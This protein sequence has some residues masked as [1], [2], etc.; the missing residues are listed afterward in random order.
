MAVGDILNE[1]VA[2]RPLRAAAWLRP[3]IWTAAAIVTL[4]VAIAPDLIDLPRPQGALVFDR[5]SYTPVNGSARDVTMPH[6][7]YISFREVL[8]SVRYVFKFEPQAGAQDDLHVYV[9]SFNRRI[10]LSVNGSVFFDSETETIWTGAFISSSSLIQI[11]RAILVAGQN[12]LTIDVF[13]VD[14]FAVPVHLSEV[15]V[16]TAAALSWPFKLRVFFQSQLKI[17]AL[18]VHFVF[19]VGLIA[20]YF[21][22][23][24]DPLYSW[25]AV[26][27][28][29]NMLIAIGML[30]GWQPAVRSFVL[31]FTVLAPAMGLLFIGF[32]LALVGLRP[33]KM[34]AY[35]AIAI[36]GALVPFTFVDT[37]FSKIVL[38]A[39]GGGVTIASLCAAAM[40]FAWSAIRRGDT[41]AGLM[42]P[43]AFLL[44]W[45]A[46][47]DTFV[48]ATLPAH[49]FNLLIPYVRPVFFSFLTVVLLRR[50]GVTL[51]QLDR[52]NEN[53]S[54]RLAEREAELAIFHRQEKAKTAHLVREQERHRL[55]HDLH[56]GISGHLASIIALSERTGDKS[57]EQAAR[58]ALNDLRLVIYSLDLDDS[59]LPVALAN[60]RDRL[61]PQLHRLGIELDW[62]IAGLPEVSGVT[63][64]NALAILRILQ[65]AVTNAVKHGPA[66]RIV[67]RASAAAGD[68]VMITVENDGRAFSESGTGQSLGG[69]GLGNMRRRAAGL[70]GDVTIDALP[71]GTRLTL[72]LPRRFPAF[73]DEAAT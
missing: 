31:L 42:L 54:M 38:A 7:I 18:A 22:R 57:T 36:T 5:A 34:L 30:I 26:F 64:G 53:L 69:H 43:S 27:L 3:L 17:M 21:F 1:G 56:D 62:S 59:E 73:D 68:K 67:I 15:Y 25:L 40:V 45:F 32:S 35:M 46:V 63:P 49:G 61:I 14:R 8:P 72:L 16:G 60:F 51:D 10:K 4:A 66:R 2:A 47:R 44:V 13:D 11:P 6:A 29:V 41:D 70:Q 12:A 19:G 39:I 28:I 58:E 20:A 48:M 65:E 52:A 23:P 50:I 24:K 37:T 71:H 55:T 33:P 9:P